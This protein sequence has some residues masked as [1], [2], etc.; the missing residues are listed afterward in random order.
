V[1]N[2]RASQRSASVSDVE[3]GRGARRRLGS[4]AEGKCC[5]EVKCRARES[6]QAPGLNLSE[7]CLI[8][9][10]RGLQALMSK[11]KPSDIQ[12]K[13]K[14]LDKVTAYPSSNQ[15]PPM[16]PRL[17]SIGSGG[18]CFLS[19]SVP[20][21]FH[22]S[23]IKGATKSDAGMHPYLRINLSRSAERLA[24]RQYFFSSSSKRSSHPRSPQERLHDN[25]ICERTI[26]SSPAILKT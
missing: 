15:F 17:L 4:A 12:E 25:S 14:Y 26:S 6:S 16:R 2:K 11:H 21:P 10:V 3:A 9:V 24:V 8:M 1:T 5:S 22:I 20:V 7:G 23:T 13:T 19:I 18:Y